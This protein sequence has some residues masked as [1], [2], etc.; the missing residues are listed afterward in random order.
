MPTCCSGPGGGRHVGLG[1]AGDEAAWAP[2]AAGLVPR[3]RSVEALARGSPRGR[4]PSALQ[5][6][7]QDSAAGRLGR[8]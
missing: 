6:D 4:V 3:R 1:S 8:R 7:R 2:A 5:E